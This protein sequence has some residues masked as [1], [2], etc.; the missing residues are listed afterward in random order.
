MSA[1][2]SE[3]HTVIEIRVAEAY[4]M[5]ERIVNRMVRTA[6]VFPAETDIQRSNSEMLQERR[7]IRPRTERA[8]SQIAAVHDFVSCRR[9]AVDDLIGARAFPNRQ[10]RLRVGN[11]PGDLID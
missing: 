8:D 7:V 10:F 5:V 9:R 1:D 6:A 4:E 2:F 3:R 11:A